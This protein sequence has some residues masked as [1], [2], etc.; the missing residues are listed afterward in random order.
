MPGFRKL[1]LFFMLIAGTALSAQDS[2]D[3]EKRVK[4]LEKE[5]R[6]LKEELRKL[7]QEKVDSIALQEELEELKQTSLPSELE[8]KINFHG[9]GELHYN[10]TSEEG[11]NDT[12]DF[13][14]MVLGF[15]I[16][17]SE[18]IIFDTEV[19]FEH[20]ASELELEYAKLDILIS[21]GFNLRMGSL[22]MPVGYLNEYHEPVRFYSVERPYVQENVIPTTWQEG[23]IGIFGSPL[24]E[25][26][27]RLYLVSGLDASKFTAGSG[28]RKGRG[29]VAEAKADDLAL[30][31]R[32][33]YSPLLGL[34]LG[35]SGYLGDAAQGNSSLDDARVGLWEADIRWRWKALEL[36]GLFAQ[37]DIDDTPKIN[38]V[39]SQVIGEKT[40]GWYLEAAYHLGKLFLPEEQDLVFF[41]RHEEF[42]TQEDVAPGYSPDPANDRKVTTFGLSY[43]PLHNLAIKAD[44]ENWE[45]SAGSSWHQFNLGFGYEF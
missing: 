40:L 28:I 19:D 38:S 4:E 13:H 10:N 41:L 43:F 30:V 14:R 24:S 32:V 1:I 25:L 6:I 35:F 33:E 45:N 31:G 23:G 21:E 44:L 36:T 20:S 7:K 17:F 42:N 22:L 9:Y 15:E 11:K 29:K 5:I 34:D 16:P 12:M 39:T 26:N 8:K 2:Q 27:Y 3:L 37:L 18:R